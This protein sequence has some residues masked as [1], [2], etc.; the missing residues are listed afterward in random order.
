MPFSTIYAHRKKVT[1]NDIVVLGLISFRGVNWSNLRSHL[2]IDGVECD[3]LC[4]IDQTVLKDRAGDL[5]K[6]TG[7][8]ADLYGDFRKM[9]ERND[10]DAILVKTPD[11]QIAI[12]E[13]DDF[14]MTWEHT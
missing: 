2:K 14:V 4:D 9:L 11:N 3:A 13:C 5:E 12:Y 1:A 8:K 6:M 10:L 7:K